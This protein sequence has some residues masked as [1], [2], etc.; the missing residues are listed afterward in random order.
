MIEALG[1]N[2][3]T[4]N[5]KA[6]PAE[7][8]QLVEN[9]DG[10][11]A[12]G[13][14]NYSSVAGMMRYLSTHSRRDIVY[15]VNCAA[16][17]KFCPRHSNELALKRTGRYQKSTCSRGLILNLSFKLQIDCYPDADFAEMYKHE[18]TNDPACV[19]SRAGYVIWQS[20]LHSETA[21]TT[22]EAEVTALDYSCRELL[23][24]MDMV[25]VLVEA[26]GLQKI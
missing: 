16:W 24:T 1:L 2:V 23:P 6:N 8:K 13:D 3:G 11:V 4:M 14:F 20:K 7:A 5:G 10:E 22:M 19:K 18:K 21:L 12:H 9:A 25:A 15:D 17:Y 26:V